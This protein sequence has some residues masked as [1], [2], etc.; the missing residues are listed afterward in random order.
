MMTHRNI[1]AVVS[2]AFYAGVVITKDDVHLSYL[3]L[4][5][6]FER[7]VEVAMWAAGGAVG[8][9]QGDTLKLVEDIQTLRPT[10]FPSVPRL[11]NKFYDK[12]MGGVNAAG[13]IKARLFHRG[14]AAKVRRRCD[15]LFA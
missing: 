6:M 5:H 15:T 12:I 2:A 8:F 13:G 11:F 14:Y 9:Y 10:I 4:A 3:P 1:M 7:I